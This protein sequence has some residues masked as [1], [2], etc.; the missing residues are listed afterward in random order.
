MITCSLTKRKFQRI[1]KIP[2]ISTKRAAECISVRHIERLLYKGPIPTASYFP[3][4]V[5]P[6]GFYPGPFQNPNPVPSLKIA[7]LLQ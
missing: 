6:R 7:P 4:Y 2:R 1:R 3:D 5:F